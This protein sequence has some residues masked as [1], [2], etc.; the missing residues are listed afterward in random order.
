MGE[1]EITI[2]CYAHEVVLDAENG[3]DLQRLLQQ[4]NHTGKSVTSTTK[5][6]CMLTSKTLLKC[7]LEVYRKIIQQE[8]KFQH[9]GIEITSFGDVETEVREQT[10]NESNKYSRMLEKCLSRNI[11]IDTKSKIC[12]TRT[13]PIMTYTVETRRK[14]SKTT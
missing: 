10:D 8:M 2:L 14:T 6:K 11:S 12:K 5:T 1:N 13:R 9:L 3:D 4:F 7:K